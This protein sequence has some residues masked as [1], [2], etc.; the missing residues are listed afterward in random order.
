M[1]TL[2]DKMIGREEPIGM[3]GCFAFLDVKE[4]IRKLKENIRGIPVRPSHSG[5]GQKYQDIIELWKRID[6]L[7]GDKLT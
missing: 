6:E 5:N 7:A 2:S 4:F 3:V 1:E